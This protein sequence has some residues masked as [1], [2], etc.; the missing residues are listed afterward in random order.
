[1]QKIDLYTV[2][3]ET[4][5]AEITEEIFE[6]EKRVNFAGHFNTFNEATKLLKDKSVKEPAILFIHDYSFAKD[7]VLKFV[8]RSAETNVLS[9]YKKILYTKSINKNYIKNLSNSNINGILHKL[10]TPL[11]VNRDKNL[12]LLKQGK[13]E[14][15]KIMELVSEGCTFYDSKITLLLPKRYAWARNTTGRGPF[16]AVTEE[17]LNWQLNENAER[18][19]QES[20]QLIRLLSL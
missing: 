16:T 3:S 12:L 6:G 19:L 2:A 7:N 1:M 11:F 13:E 15:I 8:S 5:I 10:D 20:V 9:A 4:D 17:I 18:F 14:L